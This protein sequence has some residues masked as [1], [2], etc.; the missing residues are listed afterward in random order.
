VDE[1]GNLWGVQSGFELQTSNSNVTHH[2][3]EEHEMPVKKKSKKSSHRDAKPS[4]ET[5]DETIA[6]LEATIAELSAAVANLSSGAYHEGHS[7][8]HKGHNGSHEVHKEYEENYSNTNN[9]CEPCEN[10]RDLRGEKN[11]RGEK[12]TSS[13]KVQLAVPVITGLSVTANSFTVTWG[14]VASAYSYTVQYSND[15]TFST[16]SQTGIVNAPLTSYTVPDRAP[17]T[18]YFVR[19]KSYPNLPGGDTAS[20]YSAAQMIR[21]ISLTPGETPDGNNVTFLQSW[22]DEQRILF[23]NATSLLP[24]LQ[25]TV[26]SSVQRRRLQGSGVRRY[27]FIDKLS[28]VAAEYPEFW[29]ASTDLQDKLK[30]KLREIEVLRNVLVW[31]H[32]MNRIV[33]DLM[34]LTGDDAFRIANTYYGAVRA[35]ARNNVF[36]AAQVFQIL[37]SFWRKSRKSTTEEPTDPTEPEVLRDVKIEELEVVR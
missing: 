29:L 33:G 18:T 4:R 27:G 16:N 10:L 12:Q 17:E 8:Y 36:G 20:E 5:K 19:V 9:L 25:N 32:L 6:R 3:I 26:L 13:P 21:T 2:I 35:A 14:A 24:Q 11:L 23:H 1:L 22:L 37:Q 34:L 31:L 28:D 15:P 30:D 7:S